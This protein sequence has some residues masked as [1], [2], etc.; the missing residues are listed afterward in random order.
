MSGV[1]AWLPPAVRL[2][3]AVAPGPAELDLGRRVGLTERPE[4]SYADRVMRL[5]TYFAV[6]ADLVVTVEGRM[7][8]LAYTLG[9]PF[10]L[11]G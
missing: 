5:F 10:R 6:S 11:G 2:Q 8:H 1:L 9:R 7:A 3:V 4:L